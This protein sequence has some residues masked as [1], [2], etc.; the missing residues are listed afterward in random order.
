M[1]VRLLFTFDLDLCYKNKFM[2]Y[3]TFESQLEGRQY[4][5]MITKQS[6]HFEF[7]KGTQ[8]NT[9]WKEGHCQPER[10]KNTLKPMAG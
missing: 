9:A 10:K 4:W 1:L 6:L 2:V 3:F 7:V 5:C 8:T